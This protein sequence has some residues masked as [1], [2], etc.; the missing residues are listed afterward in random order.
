MGKQDKRDEYLTKAYQAAP[1]ERLAIGLTKAKLHQQAGQIEQALA[2]LDDVKE[3][4]AKNPQFTAMLLQ[5]HEQMQNW[6]SALPLLPLAKKQKALPDEMLAQI[7]SNIYMHNLQSADDLDQTW[8]NLPREQ[9]KALANVEVYT[10]NLAKSG[11]DAA[12]EKLIRSTLKQVWSDKLVRVYG[13]LQSHKPLK[14]LRVVEGWLLARPES[15]ELNLAAGRLAVAGKNLDVGK[16]YLQKAISLGQL[17]I[18]YDLLGKLYEGE[19]E[20]SKALQ[21]YRA[22]ISALSQQ[23]VAAETSE[24]PS[25]PMTN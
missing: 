6:Q 12:A 2:T 11:Q 23:G 24:Q 1:A 10:E 14:M 9:K 7:E 19:D 22:G 3:L 13:G 16:E 17:P 25:L 8:N 4:G 20:N 15:A 18:A 5:T 21:L